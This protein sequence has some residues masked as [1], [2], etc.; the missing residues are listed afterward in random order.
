LIEQLADPTALMTYLR[1]GGDPAYFA[2]QLK[3]VQQKVVRERG[4]LKGRLNPSQSTT[5]GDMDFGTMPA[6]DLATIDLGTLSPE[7]LKAWEAAVDR[8]QGGN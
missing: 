7:Q 5:A 3:V 2:E 1:G 6:K 8:Q 4:L